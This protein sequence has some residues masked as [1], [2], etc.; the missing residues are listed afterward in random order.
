MYVTVADIRAYDSEIT[1]ESYSNDAVTDAIL[2]A[3]QYINTRTRQYFEPRDTVLILAG[4]GIKDL[5]LPVPVIEITELTVNDTEY[6]EDTDFEYLAPDGKMCP[7]LRHLTSVWR[8]RSE[9]K[10]T[11]T[12]GYTELDD[13][14]HV[15]PLLIQ[16]LCKII[17]TK[18]LK[19]EADKGGGL[20][21][22]KIDD[23]SYTKS[24][25]SA[26]REWFG[27]VEANRIASMFTRPV[28]R[29]Y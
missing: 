11:G 18:I 12:F 20:I 21:S 15:A 16:R 23:Y 19:G 22:E 1:L 4:A 25:K 14:D 2:E 7:F 17:A 28:I 24:E 10:I 9:I 8:N 6:I 29:T 5:L 27:S 3:E 26:P 13:E